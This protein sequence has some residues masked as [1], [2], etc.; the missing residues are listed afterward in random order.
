MLQRASLEEGAT[1][2]IAFGEASLLIE[3]LT[4]FLKYHSGLN[5]DIKS[6]EFLD[7]LKNS[8]LT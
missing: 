2:P 1:V 7:K 6:L 4:K 5:S 8:Q 3:A